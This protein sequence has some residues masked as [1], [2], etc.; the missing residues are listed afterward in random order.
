MLVGA[1][2]IGATLA[3]CE[4]QPKDQSVELVDV[5]ITI[6]EPTVLPDATLVSANGTLSRE[7]DTVKCVANGNVLTAKVKP[8]SW[9]ADISALYSTKDGK[10]SVNGLCR[11]PLDV[12]SNQSSQ[13]FEAKMTYAPSGYRDAFIITEI[14]ATGTT[15]PDGKQYSDDK[16]III[17]NASSHKT[18][19]LDGYV[20]LASEFLS[21]Q[22]KECTPPVPLDRSLPVK[23]IYQFP[24]SGKDYP[25]A[26]GEKV[27]ICQ[28]A[29]NHTEGNEL[30]ADYSKA[31]FE[32]YD[33]ETGVAQKL[34][35][36]NNPN[37]PN[38]KVVFVK[39]IKGQNGQVW[40]LM[41]NQESETFAIG[42]FEGVT[43]EEF[44]SNNSNVYDYTWSIMGKTMGADLA[45]PLLFPNEWI[46]DAVSLGIAGQTEWAVASPLLDAG[47][48]S[49]STT[50]RDKNRYFKSVQ[51][52]RNSDGSWV[53]T[54]NSTNDFTVARAT[55]L[56]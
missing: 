50:V 26:P 17:A 30:S 22:K 41:N 40:W 34:N 45:K 35:F 29:I 36:A 6:S 10:K 23:M 27:M 49:A 51:R 11:M 42:R 56:P 4:K 19:Y 53:D 7:G 48:I 21:S 13:Q 9:Q 32:W 44:V 43:P 52:K 47:F 15:K 2:L 46:E 20:L 25:V 12:L 37:V 8:G 33:N 5:T 18:L 3:G 24:G 28:S 55:M 14:F 1:L 31:N 16:Y 39:Q 38:M 54:N